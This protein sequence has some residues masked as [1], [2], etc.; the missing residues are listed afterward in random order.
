MNW[1][2]TLTL[3][4]IVVVAA[5]L[6]FSDRGKDL[7]QKYLD[8]YITTVGNFFKGVTEGITGKL[9]GSRTYPNNT[10]E[11]TMTT[12]SDVFNGQKFDIDNTGFTGKLEYETIM[13]GGQGINVKD[14]N[15]IEFKIY[16]MSGTIMI[17]T[18]NVIRISGQSASVE[19]N[20]IVFSPKTGEKT[21]EFSLVG[22][23]VEYVISN[24]YKEKLTISGVSGLLKLKELSPLTLKGDTL[25]IKNFLGT[26]EQSNDSITMTGK[27]EKIRLNNVDL[28]LS[29]D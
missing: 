26:I 15:K 20:G 21:I 11:A 23:P 1:K 2:I 8:K 18:N 24:I 14:D 12:T 16:S 6:I 13:I 5:L 7:K 9:K 19:L 29:K 4:I 22:K 28:I 3:F 27:V 10:F 17:D 25:E